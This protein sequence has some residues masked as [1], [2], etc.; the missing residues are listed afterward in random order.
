MKNI[1]VIPAYKPDKSLIALIDSINQHF[2]NIVVVNDGSIGDEYAPI[3]DIIRN[4]KQCTVLEHYTN[5]GKGRALKTAFNYCIMLAQTKQ[6]TGVITVDADGQHSLE[7][8]LKVQE[9]MEQHPLSIVLGCRNFSGDVPFRSKFG[10]NITKYVFR[11]LCGIGISDTQTG[12]R[13]IPA[14]YLE[15]CCKIDGEKYEYETNVLL[16][17]KE[18]KISLA[19]TSIETIYENNNQCSHFN[20]L[21][22]SIK[23]YKSIFLYSMSSLLAVLIDFIT[24][25]LLV[26][27]GIN[28]FVSTYTGRL[29]SSFLNFTTNRKVVFK[30]REHALLHFLKYMCL[31]V[32]S[33]TISAFLISIISRFVLLHPLFIKIPVEALLFFMNFYIQNLEFP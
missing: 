15:L 4:M 23:I 14:K 13:G 17:A 29:L 5:L 1:I 22:D 31:V 30:A 8:I 18:D 12:L 7:S 24:F 10:N 21:L 3:F 32:F 20:P 26:N 25:T 28:I 19:E 16:K 33:G 9:L 11:W 6:V 27:S 2:E